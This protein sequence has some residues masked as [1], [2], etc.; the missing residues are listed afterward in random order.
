VNLDEAIAARIAEQL[1]ATEHLVEESS[2]DV[3]GK[4]IQVCPTPL[5]GRAEGVVRPLT[6]PR[7]DTGSC[8]RDV[9]ARAADYLESARGD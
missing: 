6:T 2:R 7:G 1:A 8:G 9:G 5:Q 3:T 4:Q